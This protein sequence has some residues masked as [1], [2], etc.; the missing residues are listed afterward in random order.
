MSTSVYKA[1]ND[2]KL[3]INLG[4]TVP[5]SFR[6]LSLGDS[7][8]EIKES[9]RSKR[10]FINEGEEF[11]IPQDCAFTLETRLT[12]KDRV[13]PNVFFHFIITFSGGEKKILANFEDIFIK[14]GMDYML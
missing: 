5:G 6:E 9:I 2:Q 7:F 1:T 4:H 11:I 3:K 12:D 8:E 10:I 14:T 13:L